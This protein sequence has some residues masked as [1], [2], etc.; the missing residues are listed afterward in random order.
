MNAFTTIAFGCTPTGISVSSEYSVVSSL[1]GFAFLDHCH[2]PRL[3]IDHQQIV[4]VRRQREAIRA[5]P[6]VSVGMRRPI[7]VIDGDT[8]EPKLLT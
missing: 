6:T 4:L 5:A 2:V 7:N 3:G 1:R 8:F